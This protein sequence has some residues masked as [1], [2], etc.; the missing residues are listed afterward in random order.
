MPSTAAFW[1]S[2]VDIGLVFRIASLGTTLTHCEHG[3]TICHRRRKKLC[4]VHFTTFEVQ[5]LPA[6]KKCSLG[7]EPWT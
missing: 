2:N 4:K 5:R 7:L 3:Y 6:H 1:P